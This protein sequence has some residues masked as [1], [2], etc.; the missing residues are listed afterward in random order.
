MKTKLILSLLFV[1]LAVAARAQY[2]IDWFTIDGGGGSSTGGVYSVAG[3]IGQPDAGAMSGGNFSIQGGFWGILSAVQ[4]PGA[5]LLRIV[6]TSS[7]TVVVAWP[8]PSSGFSLQQNSDV[9]TANW[10]SAT[11][12]I[13]T[14]GSEYQLIVAPPAG[15]RFYRLY[16]P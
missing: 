3:T 10:I 2:S 15:N 1:F 11:N 16:H 5:P 12:G 6:L 9:G 4:S 14:V 13:S 7:N 8:A